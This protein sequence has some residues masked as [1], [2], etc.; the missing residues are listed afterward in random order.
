[1]FFLYS[2]KQITFFATLILFFWC[3]F[4]LVNASL[5]SL[6]RKICRMELL[7][8]WGSPL[9]SLRNRSKTRS[10]TKMVSI[11]RLPPCPAP[12]AKA[13]TPWVILSLPFILPPRQFLLAFYFPF[14]LPFGQCCYSR[15]PTSLFCPLHT[16]HW[17]SSLFPLTCALVTKCFLT[18]TGPSIKARY[19]KMWI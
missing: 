11:P 5:F 10:E 1:L 12:W 4:S 9:L 16:I 14:T 13:I 2:S 6:F 19:I 7:Y 17:F 3:S 18:R 15:K 8:S